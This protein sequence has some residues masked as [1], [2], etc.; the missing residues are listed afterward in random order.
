MEI[1]DEKVKA[2]YAVA[3]NAGRR[4]LSALFPETFLPPV[5]ERIITFQDACDELGD[6]HPLVENFRR[7]SDLNIKDVKMLAFLQL[8]IICA[9]L[10]EGWVSTPDDRGYFPGFDFFT[11]GEVKYKSNQLFALGPKFGS[12]FA[13]VACTCSFDFYSFANCLM[14]KTSELA[15][16][17]GS[18]FIDLWMEYLLPIKKDD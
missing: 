5:S 17:C 13:A 1:N 2:A 14:L 10:N 11:E 9:V 6:I 4:M 3:D 18:Q 15:K 16:Y 8:R 7:V 12:R